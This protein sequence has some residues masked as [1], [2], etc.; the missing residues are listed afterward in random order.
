MS[1]QYIFAQPDLIQGYDKEHP[2]T[3]YPV[4]IKDYDKF[5]EY[6]KFLYLSKDH[7]QTEE[8]PLLY[9][10]FMIREQLGYKFNDI[11]ETFTNLFEMTTRQKVNFVSTQLREGFVLEDNNM[12]SAENYDEVRSII[13]KQNLL[14]EQ[15]VYKNPIVQEWANKALLAKQKKSSN[16]TME[17]I[18]TTVKSHQGLTYSQVM[19]QSIYQTYSDFYRYC[20]EMN[21]LQSSL[22]AT[23]STEKIDIE[24]F[25]SS[26]DL[27][28]SP[29]DDLFVSSDKL[30]GLNS[31]MKK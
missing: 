2:I 4:T 29:Y 30:N 20:K 18:V 9:L 1:L 26:L 10:I 27:Y 21:F 24:H 23:V 14:F 3:I 15:K 5:H 25:A 13:M 11:I 28:K 17:D 22:F 16:I 12:I 8:Y 19:E 6:A 31:I 7:F